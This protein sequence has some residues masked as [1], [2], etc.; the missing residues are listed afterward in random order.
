M[1]KISLISTMTFMITL[2]SFQSVESVINYESQ[3]FDSLNGETVEEIQVIYPRGTTEQ[4]KEIVRSNGVF[5]FGHFDVE[6]CELT[7][8]TIEI[9]KLLNPIE[10]PDTTS[11]EQVIKPSDVDILLRQIQYVYNPNLRCGE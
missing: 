7:N 10:R 6:F 11:G 2:L 4:E 8:E 9:W 5:L 1:R 3:Y